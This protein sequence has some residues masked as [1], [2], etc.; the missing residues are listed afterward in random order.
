MILAFAGLTSAQSFEVASVKPQPWTGQG[1]V[2]VTTRGNTL[3]GD[4]T[5]LYGLVTFAY[6]LKDY[7]LSGGP[8]WAKH[9]RLDQSELFQVTAKAGGDKVPSEDEFRAMLQGLLAE[10]FQLRIRHVVKDLPVYRLVVAKSGSKLRE[11]PPDAKF[12]MAISGG[13]GG[14]PMRIEARH[15]A[16]SSLVSQIETQERRPVVDAT[17]LAGFYDFDV[18]WDLN[19]L[20]AADASGPSV[21]TAV[22]QLGL[23]LEAGTAPL[24][25]VVIESAQRPSAN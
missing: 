13:G 2:G 18:E 7:Q 9:G 15:A 11:S 21:F 8:D 23:R 10:R 16:L 3:L 6:G 1:G 20:T 19:G 22:Q 17:G 5:D 24:D 12:S 14:K 4:H 25:T